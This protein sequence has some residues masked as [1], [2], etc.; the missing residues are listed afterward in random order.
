V[1]DTRSQPKL[2]MRGERGVGGTARGCTQARAKLNSKRKQGGKVTE[3][4]EG[5]DRE[6]GIQGDKILSVMGQPIRNRRKKG[7]DR[8]NFATNR[9]NGERGGVGNGSSRRKIYRSFQKQAQGD[10]K[11]SKTTDIGK[12]ENSLSKERKSL[13]QSRPT[14]RINGKEKSLKDW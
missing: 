11:T 4:E 6:R 1:L 12:K 13:S 5:E 10:F 3:G 7:K 8:E 9:L 14:I 2:V